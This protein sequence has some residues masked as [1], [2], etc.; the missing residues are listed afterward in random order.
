MSNRKTQHP[1]KASE[2]DISFPVMHKIHQDLDKTSIEDPAARIRQELSRCKIS[3]KSES[4]QTVAV[5]VGSRGIH[6]LVIIVSTLIKYLKNLDLKPFVLPAMGSHGGATAEG[7]IQVLHELG[8]TES[9]VGAP[10]VPNIDVVSIGAMESGAEVYLLTAAL[11]ADHLIVV[12]RIKPHTIV[13]GEVES[14]LCKM[15]AVGCGGQLGATEMHRFG[16]ATSIVP[17][18]RVILERAPVLCGLAVVENTVGKIHELRVALPKDFVATDKELLRK[19]KKLL[20][21]IPLDDL[22]IL[23]VDEIGKNISGGGFD[24]N[25]IGFWRRDGGSRVPDYRLLVVLDL[26]PQS[27]GNALGIGLADLTTRR[28]IEKTDLE[29]T[30]INAMT[31]GNIRSVR[32]PLALENDREVLAAALRQVPRLNRV[33]MV[34]ITNTSRLETFWATEAVLPELLRLEGIK[35]D[36]TP[37]MLEFDEE[38]SLKNFKD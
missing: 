11:E 12:N 16:L 32:L 6:D 1:G 10:I 4:G 38:G 34:R 28:L 14:G 13:R 18:A 30:Y 25:V 24:P 3:D 17:A 27:Y 20:P 29:T 36:N 26:T 31:S 9:A 35:V 22:D 19:A 7:Q 23:V 2:K 33:R 8:I 15:L 37:L 21:R 5:A